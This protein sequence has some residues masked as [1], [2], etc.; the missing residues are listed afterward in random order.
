MGQK[1]IEKETYSKFGC[2][3]TQLRICHKASLSLYKQ[4]SAQTRSV[5]NGKCKAKRLH[6]F[7]HNT[8]STVIWRLPGTAPGVLVYKSW[9]ACVWHDDMSVHTKCQCKILVLNINKHLIKIEKYTVNFLKSISLCLISHLSGKAIN[10]KMFVYIH[11]Q[12]PN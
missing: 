11:G 3:T 6:L 7:M 8:H 4:S 1:R 5:K 10:R 9:L 12:V 2:L